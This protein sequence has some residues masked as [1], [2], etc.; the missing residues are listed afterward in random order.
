M[1]KFDTGPHRSSK[2]QWRSR[3]QSFAFEAAVDAVV[4]TVVEWPESGAVWPG[5][6]SIPVVRSLRVSSFPYRLVYLVLPG[7]LVI[8]ALAHDKR[9]PGYWRDRVSA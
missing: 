9:A 2:R 1:S 4:D 6:A 7:E 3:Q 8:V 5:W